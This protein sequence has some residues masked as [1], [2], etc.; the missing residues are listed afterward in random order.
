MAR[1]GRCELGAGPGLAARGGAGAGR[2]GRPLRG[3]AAE[4]EAARRAV[5]G[6][7]S[8]RRDPS[9]RTPGSGPRPDRSLSK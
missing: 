8:R 7:I 4:E 9:E 6:D 1:P 5:L 2:G 3:L